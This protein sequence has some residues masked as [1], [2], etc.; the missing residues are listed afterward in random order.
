MA[1]RAG[2]FGEVADS[3][4]GVGAAAGQAKNQIQLAMEEATAPIEALVANY[5]TA[6]EQIKTTLSERLQ[7]IDD[8]AKRELEVVQTAGLSQRDQLRETARITLEAENQKVEPSGR[9]DKRWSG[10]GERHTAGPWR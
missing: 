6:T 2:A 4:K 1:E 8:A 5:K 7:A 3:L 10:P 9:P